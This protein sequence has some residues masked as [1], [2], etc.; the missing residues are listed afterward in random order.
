MPTAHRPSAPPS[1]PWC[2]MSDKRTAH[3]HA[4]TRAV[5]LCVRC[6]VERYR[7]PGK[8]CGTCWREI[9]GGKK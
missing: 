2:R 8:L 4:L 5:T 7:Y 9:N 6:E 3:G 1:S